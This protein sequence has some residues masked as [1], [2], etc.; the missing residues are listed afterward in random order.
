MEEAD[1]SLQVKRLPIFPS[2][3]VRLV[4][5]MRRRVLQLLVSVLRQ[6]GLRRCFAAKEGRFLVGAVC[7]GWGWRGRRRA[8]RTGVVGAGSLGYALGYDGC[9]DDPMMVQRC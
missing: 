9:V 8:V 2:V 3:A 5:S 1:R 6:R 7:Y 4:L